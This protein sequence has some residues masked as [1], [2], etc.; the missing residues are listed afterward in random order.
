MNE[1]PLSKAVWR[2]SY[3]KA[4]LCV[5]NQGDGVSSVH[6]D[7]VVCP[8]V[9]LR[10]LLWMDCGYRV[11]QGRACR[12][13]L[14]WCLWEISEMP[15][16]AN[17]DDIFFCKIK[18]GWKKKILGKKVKHKQKNPSETKPKPIRQTKWNAR[19]RLQ[20][21]RKLVITW[22]CWSYAC[23]MLL[24]RTHRQNG[25]VSESVVSARRVG[26]G[27]NDLCV[28]V[29]VL[30]VCVSACM[31]ECQDARATAHCPHTHTAF[32][33]LLDRSVSSLICFSSA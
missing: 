6:F 23:I 3:I 11:K 8:R 27:D 24:W 32:S 28:C 18:S 25:I 10:A 21:K 17:E 22:W 26:S 33:D 7:T 30:W 5:W 14:Y 16:I 29:Y 2:N 1:K 19:K 4:H 13:F 12:K 9:F 15:V 20:T 31:C